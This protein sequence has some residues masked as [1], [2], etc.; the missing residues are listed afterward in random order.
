MKTCEYVFNLVKI[1]VYNYK[2]IY[3]FKTVYVLGGEYSIMTFNQFIYYIWNYG[4]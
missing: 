4:L 3:L 2:I 1:T